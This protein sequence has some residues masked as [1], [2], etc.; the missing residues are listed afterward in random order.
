[1]EE[2]PSDHVC[3]C[4]GTHSL[5]VK[6]RAEELT[7]KFFLLPVFNLLS[8]FPTGG[9]QQKPEGKRIRTS[10]SS[11]AESTEEKNQTMNLGEKGERTLHQPFFY[12]NI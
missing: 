2:K 7:P 8:V 5:P 1:M 6:E 3:G 12:I 9:T 11:G 4:G 10:Q